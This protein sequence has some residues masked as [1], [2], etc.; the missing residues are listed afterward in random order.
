MHRM[1]LIPHMN[2]VETITVPT[3][4]IHNFIGSNSQIIKKLI[5]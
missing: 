3:I 4:Q 2:Q 1:H 5:I